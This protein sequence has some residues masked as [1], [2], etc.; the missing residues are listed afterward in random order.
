MLLANEL[1]ELAHLL[2]RRLVILIVVLAAWAELVMLLLIRGQQVRN[3]GFQLG[4]QVLLG[5]NELDFCLAV[6]ADDLLH[7]VSNRVLVLLR[8]RL[9]N[10]TLE[11]EGFP[12]I[13]SLLLLN[14]QQLALV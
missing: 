7:L 11:F 1:K 10:R 6:L 14:V 12:L 9:L 4:R 5:T 13:L 2:G 8:V 3:D